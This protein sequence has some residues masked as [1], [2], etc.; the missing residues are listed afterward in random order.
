M[1]LGTGT[2]TAGN[3][4]T[5]TFSGTISGPGAFTK[6]GSGTQIFSGTNSYS[7]A[8]TVSVGNLQ[9]NGSSPNSAVTIASAAT[10]S[11]NG[12]V[13]AV[14]V[15]CR[16]DECAGRRRAGNFEQRRANLGRRRQLCLGNQQRHRRRKAAA[17]GWDWLNLSG[18]LTIT[19]NSGSKFNLKL[20]SL[21]PGNVRRDGD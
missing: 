12:T 14:T 8:T 11:G 2:L 7:G 20:V 15:Q 5:S 6:V 19:A 9:V 3:A 16:R 18:A 4:S 17:S 21:T 13:G 10:L 1:V